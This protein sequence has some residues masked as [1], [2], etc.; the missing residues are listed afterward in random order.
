[1]KMKNFIYRLLLLIIPLVSTIEGYASVEYSKALGDTAYSQARYADAINIYQE[2]IENNGGSAELYYNIG[3]AFFR[4]NMI[5]KA[6]LNYERALRLSPSDKDAKANLE[7]AL[8]MTK[9]EVA[10]QYEPFL[11][12]WFKAVVNAM[13]IA[14]WAVIALVAFFVLLLSLFLFF[15]NKI[16]IIR[17]TALV[18]AIISV[19][20]TI[21]ANIAA[22]HIYNY[23]N[24]ETKAIVM[25]EEAYLKSTP[26]NSGTELIK[27]HEGRKV[28][29]VDDT[30]RDWKEVELEDGTVGWLPAVAIERI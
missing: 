12:T 20:V 29:I 5:G 18:F 15:F 4:S 2:T 14:S 17:K 1:M 27:I 22:S 19:F 13:D 8:S 3:N 10:E 30:M 23:M 25:R 7:Y 24:D 16:V 26:D 6:I 21:F 28:K 11:V 9:D